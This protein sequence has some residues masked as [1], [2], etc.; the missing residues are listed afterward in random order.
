[1]KSSIG[2]GGQRNGLGFHVGDARSL[3]PGFDCMMRG[4]PDICVYMLG[5]VGFE[6]WIGCRKA[7]LLTVFD[8]RTT[9]GYV[10]RP[11]QPGGIGVILPRVG[12]GVGV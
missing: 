8:R 2:F 10:G 12:V 4:P 3:V 1:V 5:Q 7:G 9:Y 6:P 11:S